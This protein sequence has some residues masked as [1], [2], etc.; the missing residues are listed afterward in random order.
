V[1]VWKQGGSRLRENDK[2]EIVNK[3]IPASA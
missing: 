3:E 1:I 2:L